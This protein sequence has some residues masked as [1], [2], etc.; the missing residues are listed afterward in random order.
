MKKISLGLILVLFLCSNTFAGIIEL[1]KCNFGGREFNPKQYLKKSI[2][3]DT[4]KNVLQLVTVMTDNYYK[5]QQQVFLKTF[6]DTKYLDKISVR[7]YKIIYSDSMFAKGEFN[8]AD[9]GSI[10]TIEIDIK[11]K[12]AYYKMHQN[13]NEPTKFTCE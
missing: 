10:S 11:K 3:I 2:V 12:T 9:G 5:D 4:N 13:I 6:G 1:K 8:F 7:E